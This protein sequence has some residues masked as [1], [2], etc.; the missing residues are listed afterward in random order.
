MDRQGTCAFC[1][2]AGTIYYLPRCAYLV[3]QDCYTKHL[4]ECLP[5]ERLNEAL[6]LTDYLF[7]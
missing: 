5:C 2:Q 3:C 4:E 6:L 1:G 7:K